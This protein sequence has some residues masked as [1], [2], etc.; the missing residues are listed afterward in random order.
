MNDTTIDAGT[1]PA[2]DAGPPAP[3]TCENCD[4]PLQGHYCHHCGQSMHNPIRHAGHAIEEFFEAFWHLDG[5]V[6]RTLR[7][8]M[9]PGR[10]ACGYIEGHRQRYIAPLRLFVILSVLA[11]FIGQVS[12]DIDS[13]PMKI[14]TDVSEITAATTEEE[15]RQVRD[16]MLA[17][18]QDAR[19]GGAQVPGVDGFLLTTQVQIRGEAADRIAELRQA[20]G[21]A[22]AGEDDGGTSVETAEPEASAATSAAPSVFVS[23][24]PS[25]DTGPVQIDWLPGFVNRWLTGRFAHVGENV[26]RMGTRRDLW[27]QAILAALPTALFLLV[28]LFALLLKL[29]YVFKGRL[30]LEHLVVALYSHVFL[31]LALTA[32]FLLSGLGSFAETSIRWLSHLSWIGVSLLLIWM[33]TY[34]LLMQKRV[35]GQGWPMTILKYVVIGYIYMMLLSLVAVLTVV[36]TLTKG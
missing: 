4:T 16:R 23:G 26:E 35:Y 30:Y 31:L 20:S 34:L 2:P 33:P 6:F 5:R 28:P 1:A 17:D 11:F 8:L 10:V 13:D 27:V 21:A 7:D 15:V 3:K 9:V 24:T 36:F 12:L 32:V 29:A 22:P 19:E 18:L 14:G 25:W